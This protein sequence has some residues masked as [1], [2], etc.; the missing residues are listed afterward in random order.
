MARP[1]PEAT[2][3]LSKELGR[4]PV[5]TTILASQSADTGAKG[6]ALVQTADKLLCES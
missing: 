3:R 5:M 2:A 1:S 4:A 6:E